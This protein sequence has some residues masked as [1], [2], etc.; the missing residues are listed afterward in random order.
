MTKNKNHWYDG[1]FYDRIIAPNQDPLFREIKNLIEP[2][3]KVI[4]IGCGTGRLSFALADQCHSVLGI[5]LSKRNIDRANIKL[6]QHP[7]DRIS[8]LHR[9][10][11]EIRKEGQTHFDY[12][13][14]TFVIHEVNEEERINILNDAFHVADKI[15][16]GDYLSPKP[17]GFPGYISE[18][19][20]FMAGREHYKNYKN[21]MSAGGIYDLIDKSELK[22]IQKIRMQSSINHLVVLSK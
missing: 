22:I 12:A 11:S 3:S 17:K 8:F 19:I 18:S 5:E 1:W 6:Q 15:I 16:I 14:L 4:D 10:L 20:E 9:S 2:H 21:F 7:N 13:V